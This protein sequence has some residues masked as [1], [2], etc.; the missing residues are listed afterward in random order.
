MIK[1]SNKNIQSQTITF[2]PIQDKINTDS[3]FVITATSSSNLKVS[4]EVTNGP[5]RLIND[6]VHLTGAGIIAIKAY[7]PGNDT[8]F[9]A[10]KQIQTFV[11]WKEQTIEFDS[12][13]NKKETDK[14]FRITARASS[15]LPVKYKILSGP[16]T[17]AGNTVRL[18]GSGT[19]I[20]EASQAGNG[21]IL[22]A[23]S[24]TR[25]FYVEEVTSINHTRIKSDYQIIYNSHNGLL[26]ILPQIP[27]KQI[28][29]YDITGKSILSTI[30]N[31]PLFIGD[32]ESGIYII[33]IEHDS[34]H[35]LFK[36]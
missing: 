30:Y 36:Y 4:F 11:S 22:P 31:S 19:V 29:I 35:K 27:N 18:N 13:P 17:I 16:A 28:E 15:G 12:I 3:A 6:T 1:K 2:N 7:Q 21:T 33:K 25:E 5:A 14:N 34:I 8:V 26:T 24:T 9:A 20:I 23:P 10:P 32:F